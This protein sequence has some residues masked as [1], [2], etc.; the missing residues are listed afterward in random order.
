LRGQR[1]GS[2][3]VVAAERRGEG[4]GLGDGDRLGEVDARAEV[5]TTMIDGLCDGDMLADGLWLALGESA[6][7]GS[8]MITGV[9]EPV[10]TTAIAEEVCVERTVA[11]FPGERYRSVV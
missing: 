2:D 10:S 3:V 8:S 4:G 11:V 6:L 7:V 1:E 5:R 9:P